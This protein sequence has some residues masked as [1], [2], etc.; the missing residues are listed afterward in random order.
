MSTPTRILLADAGSAFHER[1]RPLLLGPHPPFSLDCP[2][3]PAAA[4]YAI[5]CAAHDVYLIDQHW[6]P[7]GGLAFVGEALR[8]GSCGPFI[9]L[10]DRP[11][12]GLE[13][14]GSPAGRVYCLPTRQL[15][16]EQLV[17]Q[18]HSGV[19]LTRELLRRHQLSAA[20]L[21]Q[22]QHQAHELE[23]NAIR[24]Q[25]RA[26]QAQQ[27]LRRE[28]ELNE[29]KSRFLTMA[30]HEFRTPM[31]TI[32]S[33]AA[34]IERYTSGEDDAK[35]RKHVLRIR[36][37]V[38]NLD[39]I[40]RDFLVLDGLNQAKVP[41]HPV[42][43]PLPAFVADVAEEAQQVARPGQQVSYAH[44]G[45]AGT[46]LTDAQI[47]KNILLNL[48]SN[49]SKYSD[50]GQE[51]RL[52]S[53]ATPTEL[54]LTVQDEGMGIP[55]DEQPRLFTD[56]FR[57]RNAAR[58]QGTGLGLYLVKRYVERLGGRISFLSEPDI[59]STFTVR[60]PLQPPPSHEND[61]VD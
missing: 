1:L 45:A 46:V 56:F 20:L 47:L 52:T 21:R 60:L 9:L 16:L 17:P 27:A 28:R 42:A 31:S 4:H 53:E 33:S 8:R 59:G 50:Q 40:L 37:A 24:G 29:L 54:V 6:G 19:Q 58:I 25:V 5:R 44:V 7:Q 32:L 57:A 49:A 2:S 12:G 34:L 39:G 22:V 61:T 26:A 11:S 35:R 48:L 38:A 43:V 13:P 51:I 41:Y 10:T 15:A 30:S 55:H 3:T 23:Q 36:S 18:L 14:L